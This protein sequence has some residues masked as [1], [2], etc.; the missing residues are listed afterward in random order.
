MYVV[1]CGGSTNLEAFIYSLPTPAP[2][3]TVMSVSCQSTSNFSVHNATCTNV[4]G[5]GQWIIAENATCS[6]THIFIK[7]L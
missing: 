5:T 3:G 6:C 4:S 2:V 7:T 1:D